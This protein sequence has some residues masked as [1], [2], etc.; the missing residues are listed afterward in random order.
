MHRSGFVVALSAF[1]HSAVD[2]ADVL[3]PIA[4]FTETPGTFIN[5][6]GRVQSFHAAARPLGE[7]RPAWKVLRVLGSLMGV[8]GFDY[9][10]AEQVRTE[11]LQGRDV[12]SL[13]SNTTSVVVKSAGTAGAGL[14]R[15]ADV[16]I[17]F[18][19][20]LVRRSKPLQSTADAKPPSACMN[21]Q[22][23]A[24]LGVTA[25]DRVR[26]RQGDGEAEL[27][28]TADRRV[29]DRTVRISA[30]HPWT[31]ALGPMFGEISVEKISVKV[32]S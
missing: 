5:T 24:E 20:P 32:A 7:A 4:P 2:Y 1:R 27:A 21:A 31:A 3:L 15:V 28:V 25:G 29:P 16:P 10:T 14:Q 12:A 8:G 11:C 23:M 17:Y 26:V 6:E 13:L 19:D 30:A 22:L 18:A 9:E